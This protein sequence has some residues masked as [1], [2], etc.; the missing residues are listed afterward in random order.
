MGLT[1]LL[2]GSGLLAFGGLVGWL[3]QLTA[4]A[5]AALAE[6][7]V[8][9]TRAALAALPAGTALLLE[10]RVYRTDSAEP[11][12]ATWR[13]ERFIRW[14]RVKAR[15]SRR[16]YWTV[17]DTVRPPLELVTTDGARIALGRRYSLNG[18]LTVIQSDTPAVRPSPRAGVRGSWRRTGLR[19]GAAITVQTRTGGSP[20]SVL[21]LRTAPELYAGTVPALRRDRA[22]TRRTGRWAQWIGLGAGGVFALGG[23][24]LLV[25]SWRLRSRQ[26]G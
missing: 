7:P 21:D 17:P 9:R 13:T 22:A 11:A 18:P 20:D 4:S 2:V 12:L 15:N 3:G 5:D 8:V 25:V 1:M 24:L 16:E 23:I 6:Q 10:G 26:P 19:T 14:R